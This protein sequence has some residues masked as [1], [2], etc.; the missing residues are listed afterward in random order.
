MT[1]SGLLYLFVILTLTLALACAGQEPREPTDVADAFVRAYYVDTDI[2]GAMAYCDGLACKTLQ[3]ELELREGQAISQDTKRPSIRAERKEVLAAQG[4]A[5]RFLYEISVKP[6][7]LES[8]QRQTYIKL[9]RVDDQWKVTQF[10]ELKEE[11]AALPRWLRIAAIKPQFATH[12]PQGLVKSGE[13][14]YLSSVTGAGIGYLF[15]FGAQ[16]Q[17]LRQLTLGEDAIYHPG[18]IDQDKNGFIWVPVAEYRPNGRSIIY[19]VNP[20]TWQAEAAFRVSDHIGGLIYNDADNT[21]IGINWDAKNFYRWTPAGRLIKKMDNSSDGLAH[22]DCKSFGAETVL[23]S[24]VKKDESGGLTVLDTRTLKPVKVI[25]GAPRTSDGT[26][27]TRNPMALEKTAEGW[28][29][30]FLPED[31]NATLYVY[32]IH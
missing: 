27:L 2:Q 3:R 12:H 25:R 30:Y 31:K 23:C 16:G 15:H 18:G 11:S 8:F 10:F 19:K 28:R 29:Y 1:R 26:L 20:K 17:L 32:E 5:Q 4:G 21:L 13:T 7:G 9:R 6:A 14:F 24:G 22:Q